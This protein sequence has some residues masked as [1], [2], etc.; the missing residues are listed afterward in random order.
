MIQSNGE[1]AD[2]L[3]KRTARLLLVVALIYLS[4]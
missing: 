4:Q 3:S 2:Y 1:L